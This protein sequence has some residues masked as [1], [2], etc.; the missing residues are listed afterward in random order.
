MG[1]PI[2]FQSF[3]D[4][5]IAKFDRAIVWE[6]FGP[7][8]KVCNE[9]W[10]L[11]YEGKFGGVLY[12]DDDAL[13]TGCSVMRPSTA[14]VEDLFAVARRVPGTIGHDG[15]Y[16]VLD[17]DVIANMPEWLLNALPVPVTVVGSVDEILRRMSTP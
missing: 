13:V 2:G 8:A 9:G 10:L 1:Y 3:R 6:I 5:K 15:V 11:T 7:K 14:A 16:C 17:P 12:L 4:K